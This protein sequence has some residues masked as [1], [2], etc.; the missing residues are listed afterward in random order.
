MEQLIDM[1]NKEL[2]DWG[3]L[4]SKYAATPKSLVLARGKD[5]DGKSQT[6]LHTHIIQYERVEDI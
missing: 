3:E 5:H 2:L 6:H 1:S 4:V